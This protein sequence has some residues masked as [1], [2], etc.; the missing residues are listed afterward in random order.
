MS[1]YIKLSNEDFEK[2]KI[3]FV[4]SEITAEE[5][6]TPLDMFCNEEAE[7][8]VAVEE[9][10]VGKDIPDDIREEIVSELETRLCNSE[11]VVDADVICNITSD[12]I[13]EQYPEFYK[14][15]EE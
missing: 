6:D 4:E 12:V 8:R 11:Y 3:I 7:Y 14:V 2:V 13:E 9:S 10:E 15:K 1:K 5:F